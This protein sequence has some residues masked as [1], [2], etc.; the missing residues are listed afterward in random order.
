MIYG[1][2]Q[3]VSMLN[4]SEHGIPFNKT[5]LCLSLQYHCPY[6]SLPQARRKDFD[7]GGLRARRVKN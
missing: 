5:L 2:N 4:L 6:R 7:I 3:L 1:N